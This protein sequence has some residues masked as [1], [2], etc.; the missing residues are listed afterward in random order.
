MAFDPN[1]QVNGGAKIPSPEEQIRSMRADL[2]G[3]AEPTLSIPNKPIFDAD[4]PVFN[5]N[6]VAPLQTPRTMTPQQQSTPTQQ[7]APASGPSVEELIAKQ[8]GKN[9]LVII[10]GGVAGLLVLGIAAYFAVPLFTK[11]PGAPTAPI[12]T[13]NQPTT[14][15]QP[16][17][18]TQPTQPVTPT[19]PTA[20][21][22]FMAQPDKQAFA[23]IAEPLS[24]EALRDAFSM[25]ASD[26]GTT[27]LIIAKSSGAA[28]SFAD[29]IGALAPSL[30]TQTEQIFTGT[31]TSY[32]VTDAAGIWPGYVAKVTD[33]ATPEQIKAWFTALE[34]TSKAPFFVANPGTF[35]PFKNGV[36]ATKYPNRYSPGST[37]GA[38]FSYLILPEK[39][40]VIVSTSFI[41]I[42]EGVRLLGL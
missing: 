11:I 29:I 35:S 25:H 7:A 20:Q 9:K 36:I 32:A 19:Q 38:S 40:L 15:T 2:A 8:K 24:P 41:G 37:T 13:E 26:A 42:K 31:L 39:K 4:E 17:T 3:G 34:K 14:P 12:V 27:E 21:S 6:T 5:P 23:T 18:P 10:A 1:G 33:T 16:V 30:K 28:F 22:F